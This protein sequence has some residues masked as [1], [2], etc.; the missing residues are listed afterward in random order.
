[1]VDK[2]Y[3]EQL[4]AEVAE[5]RADFEERAH[6]LDRD[7]LEAHDEIMEATRPNTATLRYI[8]EIVHK[9]NE[10]AKVQKV[11][12]PTLSDYDI[13]PFT[14][15]QG[16]VISD[17]IAQLRM[18][19]RMEMEDAIDNAVNPLLQRLANLEGKIDML[20]SLLGADRSNKTIEASEVI[21]KLNVR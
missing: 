19:L 10:D 16:E 17:L 13:P 12:I 2:H 9:T 7:P 21:R 6:L 15:D 14:D 5:V 18:D 3:L 20:T 4:R 1:M 8:P 11:G